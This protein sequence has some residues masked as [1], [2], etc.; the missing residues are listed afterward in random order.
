MG[1]FIASV[2]GLCGVVSL[3]YPD[4]IS[5]PKTY[6]DGLEAE[7]GGPAAVRVSITLRDDSLDIANMRTG[8]ET[9][10]RPFVEVTALRPL[11]YI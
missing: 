2:L 4:K 7:L 11:V 5:V 6:E 3:Y 9:W 1:T 10:G 8:K